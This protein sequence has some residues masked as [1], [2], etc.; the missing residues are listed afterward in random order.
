[1]DFAKKTGNVKGLTRNYI[2]TFVKYIIF[3][4]LK[5]VNAGR[6]LLAYIIINHTI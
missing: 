1:M 6:K 2:L 4:D 3:N 5:V